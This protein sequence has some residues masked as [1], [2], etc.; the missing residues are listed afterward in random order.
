MESDHLKSTPSDDAALEAW[1]RTN[2]SLPP[3]AD[4]G[5]SHRVIAALPAPPRSSPRKW[6]CL[7][8]ALAGTAIAAFK[9]ATSAPSA[10]SLP[11]ISPEVASA[12][13]QL[14]EPSILFALL[15]TAAS[16]AFALWRDVRRLAGL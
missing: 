5:F 7:A 15:V 10:I 9:I 3:L 1:L 6:F 14:S 11:A 8:G 4:V 16:L 2:A 12:L 13:A